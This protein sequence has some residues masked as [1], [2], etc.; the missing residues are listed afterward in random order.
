MPI[1]QVHNE[2][3]M[4]RQAWE[5]VFL[6]NDPFAWSFAPSI[7]QGRVFY[8]TDGCHLTEAQFRAVVSAARG[9]GPGSCYLSVIESAVDFLAR[10]SGHWRCDSPTYNEY[11]ALC[12]TLENAI[13]A[14]DGS[15]GLVISHEEHAV[16]GGPPLFL[17][18]VDAQYG[19]AE[20][21]VQR[22]RATWR[23][24]PDASWV[25][26]IVRRVTPVILP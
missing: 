10:P 8:P 20:H 25:E 1:A 13:Y 5:R 21:D 19:A 18:R 17:A 14:T 4:L 16:V 9:C 12:L 7:A 6:A 15:W 11:S 26:S 2:Q 22:L 24:H 23:G 3:P